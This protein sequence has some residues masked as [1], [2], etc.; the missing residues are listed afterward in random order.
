MD[1]LPAGCNRQMGFHTN[2]RKHQ[3]QSNWHTQKKNQQRGESLDNEALLAGDDN[4]LCAE[5]TNCPL[6]LEFNSVVAKP[7]GGFTNKT[8]QIVLS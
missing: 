6:C 4:S 2:N 8:V 5:K 7:Y 1:L 3:E